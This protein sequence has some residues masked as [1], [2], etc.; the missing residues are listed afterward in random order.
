MS[1]IINVMVEEESNGYNECNNDVL[2]E[3]RITYNHI[4]DQ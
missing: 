3:K 4:Y 2:D 1:R